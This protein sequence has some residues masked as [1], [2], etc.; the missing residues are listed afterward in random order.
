VYIR[1]DF[2]EILRHRTGMDLKIVEM[3]YANTRQNITFSKYIVLYYVMCLY[4]RQSEKPI[5][6]NI[7]E[8]FTH[9]L[10]SFLD[11]LAIVSESMYAH[12][13]KV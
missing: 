10:N 5:I 7:G 1:Q 3:C 11:N 13:N 4:I 2:N 12:N 6:C 9:D 8:E